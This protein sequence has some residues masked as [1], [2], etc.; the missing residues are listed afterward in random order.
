MG[1]VACVMLNEKVAFALCNAIKYDIVATF[2]A[3]AW[4]FWFSRNKY[5]HEQL[6]LPP[7]QVATHA[8]SLLKSYRGAH[9]QSRQQMRDVFKWKPPDPDML[10]LN[11]DG[12][13]FVEM[14]KD[15]MGAILRNSSGSVLMAASFSEGDVAEPVHIEV[16]SLFCG[17]QLYASMGI[18]QIQVESDCL[19]AIEAVQQDNM[20][21]SLLGCFY[22]ELKKLSSCFR[23]CVFQHVY[24]EANMATHCLAHYARKVD[25]IIVEGLYSGLFISNLVVWF[26]SVIIFC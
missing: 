10:K 16:I 4:G 11:V 23:E 21:N 24:R 3:L 20:A 6:L 18:D 26:M 1:T 13:V 15:G 7:H 22:S 12:A 14:G 19:L 2:F 8:I 17:L 25:R 5:I 9:K